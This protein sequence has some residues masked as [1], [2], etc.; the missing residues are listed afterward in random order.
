M[1][2]RK[3]QS[4]K[5]RRKNWFQKSFISELMFSA[6]NSQRGCPQGKFRIMPLI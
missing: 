1:R 2:K 5:Q 4:Q 6:K 3:W